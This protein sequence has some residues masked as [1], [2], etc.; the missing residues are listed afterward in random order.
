MKPS[1]RPKTKIAKPR[2]KKA[3]TC[4]QFAGNTP[5]PIIEFCPPNTNQF[6]DGF[7]SGCIVGMLI[8][9]AVFSVVRFF[10]G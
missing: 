2:T 3:Q 4:I 9:G 10:A 1:P 7:L 6:W 5:K 8:V